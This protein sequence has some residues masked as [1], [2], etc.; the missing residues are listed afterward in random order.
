MFLNYRGNYSIVLDIHLL[1][2]VKASELYEGL[3][4]QELQL[5]EKC[6]FCTSCACSYPICSE[7]G[8]SGL[9]NNFA[10]CA[11]SGG[12]GIFFSDHTKILEYHFAS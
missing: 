12:W 11:F 8:D 3:R 5:M 6:T 1:G 9:F 7:F 4:V 2:C 10:F